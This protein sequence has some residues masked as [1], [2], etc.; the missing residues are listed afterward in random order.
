MPKPSSDGKALFR[1]DFKMERV[2]LIRELTENDFDDAI[3]VIPTVADNLDSEDIVDGF[4]MIRERTRGEVTSE[5][6]NRT[7]PP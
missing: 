2:I 3:G 5:F 4:N 1:M 7:P 6:I